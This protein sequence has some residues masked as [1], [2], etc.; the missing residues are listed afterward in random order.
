MAAEVAQSLTETAEGKQF[1]SALTDYVREAIVRNKEGGKSNISFSE[2]LKQSGVEATDIF[3]IPSMQGAL[4]G[5]QL[6]KYEATLDSILNASVQTGVRNG[7]S[8]AKTAEELLD[9]QQQAITEVAS[10]FQT[11]NDPNASQQAKEQA[12]MSI[13]QLSQSNLGDVHDK[14][15]PFV[16]Y[17]EKG[18][19]WFNDDARFEGFD[20]ADLAGLLAEPEQL[21]AEDYFVTDKLDQRGSTYRENVG[22]IEY[23]DLP[24]RKLAQVADID[25]RVVGDNELI[26][27]AIADAIVS[28]WDDPD[29]LNSIDETGINAIDS[30][31]DYFNELIENDGRDAVSDAIY[32]RKTRDAI[33][34]Q[35]ATIDT[36]LSRLSDR[37]MG[38]SGG[39]LQAYLQGAGMTQQAQ[40]DAAMEAAAAAQE[41]RDSAA[42]SRAIHGNARQMFEEGRAKTMAEAIDKA[43]KER[44][45]MKWDTADQNTDK[46]TDAADKNFDWAGTQAR[47][48]ASLADSA[49]HDEFDAGRQETFARNRND[50]RVEREVYATG[51]G[52]VISDAATQERIDTGNRAA[53]EAGKG[54]AVGQIN[55]SIDQGVQQ[56]LANQ[57]EDKAP[58]GWDYA[59]AILS[60]VPVVSQG[61]DTISGLA[62]LSE[63]DK[64]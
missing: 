60:G 37:G 47:D 56:Q 8:V 55:T 38:S 12:A 53:R 26:D 52:G 31:L 4:T 5:E 63:K 22:N 61:I 49:Y 2:V 51:T 50:E 35:K 20:S 58:T 45:Q 46:F 1:L 21:E 64:K 28:R 10:N 42:E 39:V 27:P 48:N 25:P 41:R 7:S 24:E 30:S 33:Q 54:A 57:G 16:Q 17:R 18:P 23:E 62:S 43:T 9:Y 14:K 6:K 44:A 40:F 3:K 19:G 36:A 34:R 13:K 29:F 15:S 32:N 59:S 11:L